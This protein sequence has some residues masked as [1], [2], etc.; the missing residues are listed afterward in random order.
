VGLVG[1]PAERPGA[2]GQIHAV[3][4]CLDIRIRTSWATREAA[5]RRRYATTLVELERALVLPLLLDAVTPD[6]HG[7]ADIGC[8]DTERLP[9]A[10]AMSKQ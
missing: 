7:R 8:S 2:V 10:P 1:R 6:S 5:R 3:R 9:V 4:I